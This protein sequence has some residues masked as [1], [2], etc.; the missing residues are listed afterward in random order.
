MQPKGISMKLPN[1]VSLK[2]INTDGHGVITFQF[3]SADGRSHYVPMKLGAV[4]AMLP[5]LVNIKQS[6]DDDGN[7]TEVQ[8]VTLTSARSA[9]LEDGTAALEIGLDGVMLQV[10][11]DQP[12][13]ISTLQ[14][15]LNEFQSR[16]GESHARH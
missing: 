11:L 7:S 4:N 14:K 3:K 8:P 9:Y 6:T 15:L 1:L 16:S 2:S 5:S 12:G 10:S 13:A